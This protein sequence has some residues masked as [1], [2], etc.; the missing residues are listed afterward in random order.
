MST[1]KDKKKKERETRGHEEKAHEMI[2]AWCNQ[3]SGHYSI[4]KDSSALCELC[5]EKLLRDYHEK[6]KD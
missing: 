4:C 5:K 1:N 6:K 2:C 3:R